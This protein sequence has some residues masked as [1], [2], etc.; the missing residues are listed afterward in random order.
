[1]KRKTRFYAQQK[2]Y[3]TIQN[4]SKEKKRRNRLEFKN[5]VPENSYENMRRHLRIQP[6]PPRT[7]ISAARS[8]KAFGRR[9]RRLRDERML[10]PARRSGY[11]APCPPRKTCGTMRSGRGHRPARRFF[12][13]FRGNFRARRDSTALFASGVRLSFVRRGT[14]GR[15]FLCRGGNFKR[16]AS[17]Y[18]KDE[19]I[20]KP[21]IF[22][23][24]G[25]RRIAE[26][27]GGFFT[28]I[29]AERYFGLGIR[30]RAFKGK[31]QKKRNAFARS[32]ARQL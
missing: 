10:H 23:C 31:P 25:A 1:M 24:G 21:R 14:R 20:F 28:F 27:H 2:Y 15:R 3:N 16:R 18:R 6:F 17:L 4:E 30:A 32:A 26:R 9:R 11:S 7:R 12:G 8:E 22:V 19:G 5:S 29:L 13:G